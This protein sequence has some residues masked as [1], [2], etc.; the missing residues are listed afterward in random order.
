MEINEGGLAIVRCG[1]MVVTG[2]CLFRRCVVVVC[3]MLFLSVCISH[4]SR[5]R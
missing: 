3:V 2:S 5:E 4:K 1:L